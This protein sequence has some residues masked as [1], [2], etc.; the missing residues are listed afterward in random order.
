MG[1]RHA[2]PTPS[3]VVRVPTSTAPR[4][5]KAATKRVRRPTWVVVTALGGPKPVVPAPVHGRP[6]PPRRPVVSVASVATSAR[7]RRACPGA[8][9]FDKAQG[10]ARIVIGTGTTRPA[11]IAAVRIASTTAKAVTTASGTGTEVLEGMVTI[12]A[13]GTP[14]SLLVVAITVRNGAVVRP[15][16]VGR[17]FLAGTSSLAAATTMHTVVSHAVEVAVNEAVA[18]TAPISPATAN[19]QGPVGLAAVVAIGRTSLARTYQGTTG[20][21]MVGTGTTTSCP[22]GATV[23]RGLA[24]SPAAVALGTRSLAS[25]GVAL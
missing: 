23:V 17:S 25:L 16:K 2:R 7:R 11:R 4:R 6:V 1:P 13:I 14:G 8:S 3:T 12:T 21:A 22:L 19:V 10:M 9:T 20:T 5:P 18:A 15:G 24:A